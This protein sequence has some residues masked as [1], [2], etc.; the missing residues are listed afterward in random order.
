MVAETSAWGRAI[1]AALAADSQKIASADE[2]RNRQ[3]QPKQQQQQQPER[4]ASNVVSMP[5][6]AAKQGGA[7]TEAQR[8]FIHVL[9]KQTQSDD[10]IIA[11]LTGGTSLEKLSGQQ[12][13]QVIEDLLAIKN[14]TA[15]LSYDADGKATVT[16]Q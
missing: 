13:R 12:A 16:H 14:G 3:D 7:A 6:K 11:D 9:K 10:N 5:S 15:V 8:K 4:Q 2:V 1:V